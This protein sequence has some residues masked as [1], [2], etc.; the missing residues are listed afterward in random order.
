MA[1][2]QEVKYP[3][4]K[5]GMRAQY[6]ISVPQQVI[7]VKHWQK[8]QELLFNFNK[9][10]NIELIEVQEGGNGKSKPNTI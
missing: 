3:T 10:G 6:F 9:D 2:L 4:S 1:K 7:R 5:N 8:G